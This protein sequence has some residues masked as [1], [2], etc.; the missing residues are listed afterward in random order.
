MSRNQR[1]IIVALLVV[2]FGVGARLA[3]F[4]LTRGDALL[5]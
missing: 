4:F 2:V 1:L 3:L 5:R